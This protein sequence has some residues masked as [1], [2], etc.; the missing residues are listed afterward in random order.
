M[1]MILRSNGGLT[2]SGRRFKPTYYG[3]SELLRRGIGRARSM[4]RNRSFTRTRQRRNQ[5]HGG[6]G[7]TDHYDA[8]LIY[9]KSRMPRRRRKRWKRFSK[10][11]RFVGQKDWGTQQVV[12]NSAA[13]F[14]NTTSGN[15]LT[16]DFGLY[17][18]SSTSSA[19]NDVRNISGF[20]S[21]TAAT[22]MAPATGIYV[23]DSTKIIFQSAILDVTIRNASTLQTAGV[24]SVVNEAKM[25]VDVYEITMRHT[26][27]ETGSTYNSLRDIFDQ[28]V[29]RTLPI[30]GG[31]TTEINRT[32]RGC[33]PF[34]YSYA[35]SRFGVKIWKKTKFT[36]NAGD[37]VTYQLRDP[38]TRTTVYREMSNQDGFNKPGWTK[39]IYIVGKVAPG[40]TVGGTDGTYQERLI[41]GLTRK[42]TFKI[43]NWSEDRTAYLVA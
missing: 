18:W 32:L 16:G 34:D 1:A 17:G 35:L 39:I 37:Q 28:N 20:I 14:T 43:Q 42:Y 29:P 26:A 12:Y 31:A 9:R 41:I 24:Q 2:R 7:V 33:S 13:T 8:R 21:G 5:T 36:I 4:A 22:P 10:K 40:L 23:D 25:E 15:Q 30:G 11:V 3:T 27:E 19:F 38:K 6:V